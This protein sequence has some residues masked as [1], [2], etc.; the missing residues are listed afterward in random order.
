M[1]AL[2]RARHRNWCKSRH[3]NRNAVGIRAPGSPCWLHAWSN[4][5]NG[6]RDDLGSWTRSPLRCRRSLYCRKREAESTHCNPLLCWDHCPSPKISFSQLRESLDCEKR[7]WTGRALTP[8]ATP[9]W[10]LR[11]EIS[12]FSA[13]HPR[14]WPRCLHLTSGKNDRD[15]PTASFQATGRSGPTC[16]PSS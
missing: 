10:S 14:L 16:C 12:W 8:Q 5:R 15:E 2:D 6:R 4:D 7:L 13:Q 11:I 1:R 9:A 3:D